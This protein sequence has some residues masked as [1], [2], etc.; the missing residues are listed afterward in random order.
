MKRIIE[1]AHV[2]IDLL[3]KRAGEKSEAFACFYRRTRQDNAVHLFR[4]QRRNGQRYRQVSFP[5]SSGTD[6]E[7]HVES[8]KRFNVT[9]LVRTFRGDALFAKR[10]SAS[11][12]KSTAKCGGRFAGSDAEQRFYF[13]TAGDAAFA[14]AIVIFGQN[15]SGAFHLSRRTFDFKIMVLQVGSNVQG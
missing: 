12:R 9:A 14:D 2:G 10:A 15:L 6:G 3:L 4:E 5:S 1:R 11:G 13:L 7:D 8:F